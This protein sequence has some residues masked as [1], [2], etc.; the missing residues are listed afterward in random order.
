M[1]KIISFDLIKWLC[2]ICYEQSD[3]EMKMNIFE[4]KMI[5]VHVG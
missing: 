1:A 3:D 2:V 4:Q 5:T